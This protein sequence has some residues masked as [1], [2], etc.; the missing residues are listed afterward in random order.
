MKTS[1][2]PAPRCLAHSLLAAAPRPRGS[3]SSAMPASA[4][5][6]TSTTTAACCSR[7]RTATAVR[8]RPAGGLP[9]PL[10]RQHDRRDRQRH[11]LRRHDPRRQRPGRRGRHRRARREG[12]R[13]RLG[14]LGHAHLR[15]HQRRRR[16]VGRRRPRRLLADRPRRVRRD[17]GSSPTAAASATTT[18]IQFANNPFARPTVRYDF[19][20]AGFGISL[21]SNRDLTDIVV[22]AGYSADFGGGNCSIGVGYN[23][24]DSF[25][26]TSTGDAETITVNRRRH[27]R[28]RT[29]IVVAGATVDR[30]RRQRRAV[31]GRPEGHYEKFAFGVDLHQDRTRRQQRP[32]S[33]SGDADRPAVRRLL[34]LRRLLGRRLLPAR[35]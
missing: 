12:E 22:G 11:H 9:R 7:R 21:S 27:R 34:R 28:S 31:V 20:I 16:A 29:T 4:S 30:H 2:L 10:R 35:C 19:D 23:K 15:R 8:R 32:P 3:R 1:A 25:D 14:R 33:A 24:F 18:R 6:T 26:T 17:A 13:L 5:A